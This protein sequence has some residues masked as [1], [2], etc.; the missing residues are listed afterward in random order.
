[1]LDTVEILKSYQTPEVR[2]LAWALLSAPLVHIEGDADWPSGDWYRC[3]Y[4]NLEAQLR[5]LDREPAPLLKIIG[6]RNANRLGFYFEALLEMWCELEVAIELVATNPQITRADRSTQG[7]FDFIVKVHGQVEHWESAIKFYLG[8][9]N[10]ND[11]NSSLWYGPNRKDRLDMKLGHM[12]RTQLRLGKTAEGKAWL[13]SHGL[14]IQRTRSI[15][16]GCAFYPSE[17]TIEAPEHSTGDHSK[18]VWMES[19]HFELEYRQRGRWTHL[20]R[21]KWLAPR[22]EAELAEHCEVSTIDK[23]ALLSRCENGWEVE[24]VFVVPN[25]WGNPAA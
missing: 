12:Q 18:S 15:V 7:A 23:P 17:Q 19:S 2:D 21:L 6:Q 14:E 9:A 16:K 25:G 4:H 24:R 1:M 3:A 22:N 20:P 10:P 5:V 11:P 13:D 8:Q